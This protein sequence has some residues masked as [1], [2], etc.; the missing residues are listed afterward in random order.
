MGWI[1]REIPDL[2]IFQWFSKSLAQ[3][4]FVFSYLMESNVGAR[5]T[6][7]ESKL[8]L[9]CCLDKYLLV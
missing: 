8:V 6:Q 3:L 9:E 7:T 5:M 1:F 4:D 2:M